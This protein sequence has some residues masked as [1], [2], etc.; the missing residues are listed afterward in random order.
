MDDKR[1]SLE[2]IKLPNGLKCVLCYWRVGEHDDGPEF[3]AVTALLPAVCQPNGDIRL[4]P[5]LCLDDVS[6]FG[7]PL[8]P[9]WGSDPTLP[10]GDYFGNQLC[11]M[12]CRMHTGDTWEEAERAARSYADDEVDSLLMAL[13]AVEF[14]RSP[15]MCLASRLHKLEESLPCMTHQSRAEWILVLLAD[16]GCTIPGYNDDGVMEGDDEDDE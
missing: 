6:F 4:K 8:D 1:A 14:K 15:V 13:Q 16:F 7:M 9:F 5:M 2:E 3:A 10:F 11:V 12:Q